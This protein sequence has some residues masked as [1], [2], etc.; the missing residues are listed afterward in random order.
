MDGDVRSVIEDVTRVRSVT[1]SSLTRTGLGWEGGD[2]DDGV[3]GLG[4]G[5]TRGGG[6]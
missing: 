5:R 6:L 2:G 4:G 1:L 3:A